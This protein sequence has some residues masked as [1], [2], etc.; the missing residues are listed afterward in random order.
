MHPHWRC[1]VARSG[2]IDVPRGTFPP[3]HFSD[4]R[5]ARAVKQATPYTRASA[6]SRGKIIFD[7]QGRLHAARGLLEEASIQLRRIRSTV[8]FVPQLFPSSVFT[9]VQV[10]RLPS[11]SSRR[12]NVFNYVHAEFLCPCPSIIRNMTPPPQKENFGVALEHDDDKVF[13]FRRCRW[14]IKR[15]SDSF[16]SLSP[17]TITFFN[18]FR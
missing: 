11:L 1:P 13:K 7:L 3:K 9:Y 14:D 10:P 4:A 15:C 16:E 8:F 6:L 17:R 5:P 18:F 2:L 12:C